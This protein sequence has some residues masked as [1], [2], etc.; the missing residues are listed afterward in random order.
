M[1]KGTYECS[2]HHIKENYVYVILRNVTELEQTKNELELINEDLKQFTYQVS[3]DLREPLR[4]ISNLVR[5]IKDRYHT[6]LDEKA[7]KYLNFIYE[8]S[9]RMKNLIT[10]LLD[11]S[12]IG[13]GKEKTLVDVEK[14][15]QIVQADLG[16]LVE[17]NNAIIEINDLPKVKGFQTELRLLFQNLISNGIKFSK[18]GV[19]PKIIISAEEQEDWIFIIQ[20]NGI[21][22]AKEDQDKIFAAFQRVH[23]RNEYE[24]TGLGLAHCKKIVDV[25]KGRLWVHSTQG[26]GSTFSFTIPK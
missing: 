11:Y 6:K 1:V 5:I 4:T 26:E 25:H 7:N 19:P 10:D 23:S 9:G 15:V 21:G 20:D 24:G 17:E 18:P 14:L 13:E 2:V 12:S 3:H 16:S 22:I 8:S